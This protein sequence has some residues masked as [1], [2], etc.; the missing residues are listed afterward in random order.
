MHL[1]HEMV[2]ARQQEML[3]KAA[4]QRQALRALA[5]ARATRRV[6]RA[7]HRLTRSMLHA[8]RVRGELA[9]DPGR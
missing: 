2:A 4:S 5:L 6:E 3:A 1:P 8:M 7:E 9:A